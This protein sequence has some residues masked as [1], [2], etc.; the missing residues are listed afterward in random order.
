MIKLDLEKAEETDQ[1]VIICC[2]IE[3]AREFQK[4]IC[5]IDYIKAFNS[6]YHNKLWK[7]LKQTEIPDH[8]TCLLRYL[9]AGQEATVRTRHGKTDQFHIGKGVLKAIYCHPDYLTYM[10][11][12]SCKMLGWMKHKLGSRF[13][14]EISVT[15]D[16]QMT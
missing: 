10:Q 15:S 1:I 6:V 16:M 14:G 12:A 11:S 2:I 7:I 9:Y 13:P 5:F 3:K 8:P 4:I